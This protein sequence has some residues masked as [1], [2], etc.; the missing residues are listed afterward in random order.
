MNMLQLGRTGIQVSDWCLGTMTFS[1]QT[2]QDDAFRQMDMAL[3]A[4]INF[5]D[6][7]EMYP[8][9]PVLKE[10][11]GD[12]EKVLG[13]WFAQSG[14]RDEVVVASKICGDS[15]FRPGGY[16]GKSFEEALDVTLSRLQTDYIDLFQLHWPNRGSYHFR[17]NWGFDPSKQDAAKVEANMIETLEAADRAVK[18]GKMRALGLSN[19]SA[20]GTMKWVTLAEKHG[21]PRMASIQNEYSLLCRLFD[22]DMSEVSLHE[23]VTL[24]SY[25]PLAA[26]LLTGKY[27]NGAVPEGSR[28]SINGDL[29]GRKGERA[30]VATQSYLD[31]AAKHGIDPIHMSMAWQRR[32]PFPIS[33]IFGATTTEQLAHILAGDQVSLSDELMKEIDVVHRQHPMPY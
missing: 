4:G 31:L 33:A 28:L 24:L 6:V 15:G 29:G 32:R 16:N 12:S 17:Q 19:E 11:M 7:A 22:T 23:D 25:S 9:N 2:D 18:A 21:L 5:F 13:N 1:R 27:Q 10:T 20:W 30:F 26:G 8:V 3:E 14:R